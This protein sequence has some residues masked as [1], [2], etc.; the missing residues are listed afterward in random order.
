MCNAVHIAGDNGWAYVPSDGAL[1]Q[2]ICKLA[3][4]GMASVDNG[5]VYLKSETGPVIWNS[6]QSDKYVNHAMKAAKILGKDS[7]RLSPD[8]KLVF[9]RET[10]IAYN[11]SIDMSLVK[12]SPDI[13]IKVAT[14]PIEENE[15][16]MTA[17]PSSGRFIPARAFM[18]GK[19]VCL[20]LAETQDK[21]ER[22]FV[23]DENC[24]SLLTVSVASSG[25]DRID[26]MPQA[27]IDSWLCSIGS[28]AAM[29]L[30]DR[31]AVS[32]D[33]NE[34]SISDRKKNKTYMGK[35]VS[36]DAQQM[37]FEK[38][39]LERLLVTKGLGAI[40]PSYRLGRRE[41]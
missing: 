28:K 29:G 33:G 11:G 6:V 41:Q 40:L 32:V 2:K 10:G 37:E 31:F 22:C 20:E 38:M 21:G 16:V 8:E 30:S 7:I 27:A 39:R 24:R 14:R 25:S 4:M 19:R 26:V 1:Y 17:W 36:I 23:L 15:I 12:A 13:G 9:G 35:F 3:K 34:F 18:Y 5:T